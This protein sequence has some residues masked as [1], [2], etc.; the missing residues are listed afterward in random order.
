LL[1][2]SQIDGIINIPTFGFLSWR[3]FE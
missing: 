3:D 1:T 2:S